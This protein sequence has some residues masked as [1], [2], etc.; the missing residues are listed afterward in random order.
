MNT[1][2]TTNE[3]QGIAFNRPV[4]PSAGLEQFLD[5]QK[6]AQEQAG[7]NEQILDELVDDWRKY[8]DGKPQIIFVGYG[9]HCKRSSCM[10]RAIY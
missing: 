9:S 5:E 10:R 4:I 3:E 7:R 8:P 6:L 2:K 1:D